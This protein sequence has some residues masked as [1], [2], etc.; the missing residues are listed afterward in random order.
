[1]LGEAEIVLTGGIE[2]MSRVPF[3]IDAGD[4]RWGHKLGQFTVA[5]AMYRDGFLCPLSGLI[6]GQ[7]AEILA[8]QYGVSRNESDAYAVESQQRAE[9][10][11]TTGLFKAEIALV[12]L[13][14]R[15]GAPRVVDQDEHPRFGT[16]LEALAKLPPAFP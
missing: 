6:M 9:R 7:T 16:T 1:V 10:A 13:P 11:I 3:L 4:V 14:D 2:S 15:K 12:A 5:D 8:R